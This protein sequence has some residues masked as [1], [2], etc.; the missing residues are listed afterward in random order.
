MKTSSL[1]TLEFGGGLRLS[2]Y[3]YRRLLGRVASWGF[4]ASWISFDAHEADGVTARLEGPV[5]VWGRET[6]YKRKRY[7]NADM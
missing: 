3:L 4:T 1:N 2:G 6:S 5:G 7:Q